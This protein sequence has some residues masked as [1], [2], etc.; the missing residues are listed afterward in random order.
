MRFERTTLLSEKNFLLCSIAKTVH[1]SKSDSDFVVKYL[2]SACSTTLSCLSEW[3]FLQCHYE[4]LEKLKG[5]W[6]T[7]QYISTKNNGVKNK[8]L[9]KTNIWNLSS[10]LQTINSSHK[11]INWENFLLLK[12]SWEQ[13]EKSNFLL[14]M[15]DLKSTSTS[16][17]DFFTS[18]LLNRALSWTILIGAH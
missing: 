15:H 2:K 12:N 14:A 11:N 4:T 13:P 10:H 17:D 5:K 9:C 16:V 3:S 7:N 18:C 1:S 8:Q 6:Q